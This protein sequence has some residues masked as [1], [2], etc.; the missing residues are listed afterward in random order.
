[1]RFALQPAQIRHQGGFRKV[2]V[3]GK[4]LHGGKNFGQSFLGRL[5]EQAVQNPWVTARGVAQKIR[6]FEDRAEE[7]RDAIRFAERGGKP[8]QPYIACFVSDVGEFGFGPSI[9]Q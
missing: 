6:K 3:G 8:V 1:M 4:R 9:V 2:G 7:L 5:I